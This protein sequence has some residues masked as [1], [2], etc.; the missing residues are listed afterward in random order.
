LQVSDHSHRRGPEIP[1][2]DE[3][4]GN[5]RRFGAS[6]KKPSGESERYKAVEGKRSSRL[7]YKG[8]M[9]RDFVSGNG[10]GIGVKDY[11]MVA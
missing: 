10:K 7:A 11:Y 2:V 6:Q 9:K 4:R 5:Y 1:E 3:R 8:C